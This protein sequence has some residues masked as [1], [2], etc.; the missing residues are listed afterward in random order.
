MHKTLLLLFILTFASCSSQK[1]KLDKCDCI[2]GYKQIKNDFIIKNQNVVKKLPG[3]VIIPR[4]TSK[5]WYKCGKSLNFINWKKKLYIYKIGDMDYRIIANKNKIYTISEH[6][7][8][9]NKGLIKNNSIKVNWK[10]GQLTVAIWSSSQKKYNHR[11]FFENSNESGV[12]F[13]SMKS[14]VYIIPQNEIKDRK[15]NYILI[16]KKTNTYIDYFNKNLRKIKTK[17]CQR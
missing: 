5:F 3:N 14:I 17:D 1:I 16:K 11:T 2:F 13:Y 12:I 6:D 15:F 8:K 9:L 7:P 10:P 4:G